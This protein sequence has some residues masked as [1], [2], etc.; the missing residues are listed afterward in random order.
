VT[1][2]LQAAHAGDREALE[3]VA[4]LIY[5]DLRRLARIHMSSEGGRHTLQT[6]GLVHEVYLKMVGDNAA[7]YRSR[8]H[9]FAV[10]STMMRHILV[11]WARKRNALKRGGDRIIVPL[12]EGL[13][14]AAS[15]DPALVLAVHESLE[16]LSSLSEQAVKVVECRYFAG[17]TVNETGEA[18]GVSPS[19]VKREWRTARSWLQRELGQRGSA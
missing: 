7:A 4:P 13:N 10:A 14:P 11:S 17:L 8:Q 5:D 12:V 19:T 2:L 18:L 15:V 9:F 6:T 16:R 1:Q 3:R